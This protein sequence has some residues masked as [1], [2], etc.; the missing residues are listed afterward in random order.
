MV[1]PAWLTL[2]VEEVDDTAEC[3]YEADEDTLLEADVREEGDAEGHGDELG[4]MSVEEDR[5]S[6]YGLWH[7][8][9]QKSSVIPQKP[10]W[11]QQV[12]EGQD[13]PLPDTPHSVI[14]RGDGVGIVEGS[15]RA[16][17]DAPASHRPYEDWHPR[18]AAQWS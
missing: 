5:H 7:P 9:P 16:D 4:V 17:G 6:P 1:A 8:S 3:E 10:H 15:G 18:H 14:A 2:A 12:P 13:V 11:E